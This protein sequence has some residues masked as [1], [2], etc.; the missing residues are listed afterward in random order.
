LDKLLEE[1]KVLVE[2]AA[3][4]KSEKR[5]EAMWVWQPTMVEVH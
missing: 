2:G 3:L 1:D 5:Q 4:E